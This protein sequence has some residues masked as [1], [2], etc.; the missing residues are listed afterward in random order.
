MFFKFIFYLFFSFKPLAQDSHR[1]EKISDNSALALPGFPHLGGMGL[2]GSVEPQNAHASELAPIKESGAMPQGLYHLDREEE[3][4]FKIFEKA[5][6][7]SPEFLEEFKPQT[8]TPFYIVNGHKV[9]L[10]EGFWSLTRAWLKSYIKEAEKDCSCDLDPDLMIREAKNYLPR[11]P[12]KQKLVNR[13]RELGYTASHLSARYGYIAAALK[14]SAE[15]AEMLIFLMTAGVGAHVLCNAIDVMIFPLARKIQKYVR[16]FSYGGRLGAGRARSS[17]KIFW[18]SRKIN[19]SK[20]RAF[21]YIEQALIFREREL[22]KLNQEGP[23][24]LFHKRGHRLL[25]AERLKRKTDPLFEQIGQWE[26]QLRDGY[27][28]LRKRN[29]MVKKIQA[30]RRKID[31]LSQVSRKDFFGQRFKRFLLLKSRKGKIAYMSGR[32]W[33]DKAVKKNILWPLSLGENV[34]N[35][36]V[37]SNGGRPNQAVPPD[38]I[39]EGLVEEFLSARPAEEGPL[40]GEEGLLAE[41]KQAVHSLLLDVDQIFN[42]QIPSSIRLMKVQAVEAVLVNLFA[43][44]IKT[45]SSSAMAKKLS[46]RHN[47]PFSDQMKAQ[48][49][50]G[51]FFNLIYD[52]SDFLSVVSATK[53]KTK[54]QFYKYESM[55]KLLAFLNYLRTAQLLLKNGGELEGKSSAFEALA[56]R[57]REIRAISLLKEKATAFRL[58]LLKKRA[59]RCE[60]LV[61]KYQ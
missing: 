24:S 1:L 32:R 39:R 30:A 2:S 41:Q 58:P 56:D 14:L 23:K 11:S 61:E 42:V 9:Y 51:R 4:A 5:I 17:A 8:A 25:W 3:I 7:L 33:P 55:E 16:V 44:N 13:G 45:L 26:S 38:E 19:K 43:L 18:L 48:W 15:T 31:S 29:R 37:E 50:F 53:N 46:E 10:N 49:A 36:A 60:K 52:F 34:M 6:L 12:L 57:E 54:I 20:K 27:L 40:A 22:E 47:W 35:P 59:A 28:T 21:F